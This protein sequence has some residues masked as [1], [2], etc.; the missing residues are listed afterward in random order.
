MKIIAFCKLKKNTIHSVE[1]KKNHQREKNWS[2]L[3][4]YYERMTHD[5]V[6]KS[7]QQARTTDQINH[8]K[9]F[10]C[11]CENW[12]KSTPKQQ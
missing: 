11:E 2:E 9:F 4:A 10:E 1:K 5:H 3:K 8:E 12:H 7:A 6:M